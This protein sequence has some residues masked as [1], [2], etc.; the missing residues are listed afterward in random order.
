MRNAP[1]GAILRS[2]EIMSPDRDSR[3]QVGSAG[4]RPEG[5]KRD[6]S[7]RA[8]IEQGWQ[9]AQAGRLVDGPKAMA[10]ARERLKARFKAGREH[11]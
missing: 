6:P 9:E 2:G 11:P 1:E 8:Q 10:A 7:P 3:R 4:Q 5:A